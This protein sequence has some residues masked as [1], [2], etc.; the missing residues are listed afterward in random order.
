[1]DHGGKKG[2]KHSKDG[3]GN[4]NRPQDRADNV[5]DDIEQEPDPAKND[6]LHRVEPDELIVLLEDV[7]NQ[8][9]DERNAGE[10]RRDI[11]R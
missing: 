9:A 3:A 8:T 5:A 11:R 4:R 10:S 7:K 6:R 2:P 1:M